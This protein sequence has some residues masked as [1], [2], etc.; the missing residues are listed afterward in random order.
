MRELRDDCRK[1]RP[2]GAIR[3]E[4]ARLR[5]CRPRLAWPTASNHGLMAGTKRAYE[6][7]SLFRSPDRTQPLRL[8]PRCPVRFR[9]RGGG[10][11]VDPDPGPKVGVAALEGALARCEHLLSAAPAGA[12]TARW[13]V[14]DVWAER[15]LGE[16][17]GDMGRILADGSSQRLLLNL[18][19]LGRLG[20]P[21]GIP[22]SSRRSCLSHARPLSTVF[23]EWSGFRSY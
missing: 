16:V 22:S 8:P 1:A 12:D 15:L 20:H 10:H 17:V 13:F 3:A 2:G 23:W 14:N 6:G 19:R 5:W 18:W 9:L 7:R 11:P 4:L 21:P